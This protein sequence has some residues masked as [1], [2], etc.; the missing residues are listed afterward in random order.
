M[1]QLRS[2]L[3][4]TDLS[5]SARRAADRAARL[6]LSAGAS[7]TLVHAIDASMLNE[8]RR[9][10]DTGGEVEQSMIDDA[11]ARLHHLAADIGARYRIAVD[12]RAVT[13]R[14]IDEIARAGEELE[15]DLI[16]TGTLGGGPFRSHLI[17]STAERVVRKS[18]R[19]VLMVRQIAHE[20]YRRVLVAIDFSRWSAPSLTIAAAV[21]PDAHFVLVH[22]VDVPFEGRMRLAGVSV[23]VLEKYRAA[24][25]DEANRRLAE[26]AARCGLPDDRWTA[27]APT[28]FDPWMQVVRQE[29]EQDCDLIVVGK[30]GRNAAEELLLGSTTTMV[31]AES[32]SDV[33][34]SARADAV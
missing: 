18:A 14:S 19:P 12:E 11:R 4:A 31:I 2:V 28:G 24:A 17:G 26:F 6:A 1:I 32:A 8:L 7:L 27:I 20:P 21:A 10:L 5:A 16:V 30:H 13:G 9:W 23:D 33:L 34:V 22:C 29:Q 15:T 25:G 3:A